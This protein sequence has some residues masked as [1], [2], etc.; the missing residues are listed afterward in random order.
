LNKLYGALC[1]LL[2][3]ACGSSDKTDANGP[4]NT[5]G[6]AGNLGASGSAG[7]LPDVPFERPPYEPQPG[8]CGFDTPAFCDTFEDG[9]KDGG[10]SG[11]LDPA[12]WSVVRGVPFSSSSFD[13]ADR[14]GPALISKCRADLSDTR[15]LPDSDVLVCDPIPS[16]PTRHALGTA[17]AQNYGLSTYRIRQP[18]DFA[19]RTGTIKLDMDLSNNGLGGWPALIIAG[20]PTP[21]PSFDWQERGSGPKNG[22][23]IEFGTGWCNTPHTLQTIGYTFADYVQ[24]SFVPSFDCK[25]PHTTTAPD[26]LSH[27]EIYLTQQHIEVWASDASA[28]GRDFPNFQKLWEGDLALPFS[29]GYVSLALRNHATM[30]YWLGSAASVRWDNIGFDGPQVAEV[31]D[32]SAPDSLMPYRGLPGCKMDGSP[33]CQWEGD[34]IASFPDEAGRVA[35]AMANCDYDGPGLS[36]GY[37]LPNEG[38]MDTTP[39]A[40]LDFKDVAL[41]NASRARLILAAVYPWFEWNGVNHPPQFLSLLYRVNGGVWHERP[42]DDDEANAFTDYFPDLGGAGASAGLLNQAIELDLSEL[43]AGD[44]RIELRSAHTWTGTYRV[45]ATGGDLVLDTPP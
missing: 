16:I 33:D 28:D 13:D 10:R 8:S 15:I 38:D 45:T 18:F 42:I 34:V 7:K 44:N 37:V 43:Q 39:P 23:E 11:E 40:A 12:F 6:S 9:P 4:A 27:V 22:I 19:E 5:G 35:C 41:G 3:T 30:K 29:R 25:N 2:L 32:Y 26:S 14:I 20:D 36:V 17:A 1:V 21:T 31:R 24:S